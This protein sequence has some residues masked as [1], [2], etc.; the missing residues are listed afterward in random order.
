MAKRIATTSNLKVDHRRSIKTTYFTT[1][2]GNFKSFMTGKS[3]HFTK[4]F[5]RKHQNSH[6]SLENDVLCNRGLQQ[7]A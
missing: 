6:P 2:G 3:D 4:L 5:A 1:R 7:N